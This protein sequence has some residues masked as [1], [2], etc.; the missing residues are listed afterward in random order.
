MSIKKEQAFVFSVLLSKNSYT[1]KPKNAG[2]LR[3][4]MVREYR[5]SVRNLANCLL[6][7]Y[8]VIPAYSNVTVTRDGTGRNRFRYD[9][10]RQQ[11][12]LLDIDNSDAGKPLPKTEQIPLKVA[13][14][15]LKLNGIVPCFAYR[16]YSDTPET[17]KFRIAVAFS[18][19]ITD[20][21]QRDLIQKAIGGALGTTKSGIPY[22]DRKCTDSNRIFYGTN[23]PELLYHDFDAVNS[24]NSA[25]FS[26][27]AAVTAGQGSQPTQAKMPQTPKIKAF[28]RSVCAD[29]G[30][31]EAI[32]KHDYEY[33]R[34]E[35]NCQHR[36]FK[37]TGEM[38]D[39][40]YKGVN[41]ADFL[42]VPE[43]TLFSC[44]IDGHTDKKPSA[45]IFRSD[46]GI[47]LYK[48]FSHAGRGTYNI[49]EFTE[50]VG[51]FKT[52]FSAM[53]FLKKCLNIELEISDWQQEQIS[54]LENIGS[55]IDLG[56]FAET[57]PC[58][59]KVTRFCRD[60]FR[61]MLTLAKTYCFTEEYTT[62][63]GEAVF[64]ATNS[65]ILQKSGRRLNRKQQG[66]VS[67]YLAILAYVGMIRKLPDNEV[68]KRLLQKARNIVK[69]AG[70][71]H[72]QFYSI[73][74]WVV[75]QT[76]LIETYGKSYI[77][78][79]YRQ[80][81]ISFETFYRT[82]GIE[83]AA[84]VYPQVARTKTAKTGTTYQQDKRH[85]I[86]SDLFADSIMEKGYARENAVIQEAK[87]KLGSYFS[88]TQ[89][90]RSLP[91]I[92]TA[93][94]WKRVR[95]TKKMKEQYD[96][97]SAGYPFVIIPETD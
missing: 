90:K 7:G 95:A 56:V 81:G 91:D 44:C 97:K 45:N 63:N 42:G 35:L 50:K 8:A 54:E 96:I 64:F 31:I 52:V 83:T 47:W 9:F 37:S 74:S 82:E 60:I 28:S 24:V 92:M 29:A 11:V 48:C 12:F 72:I 5:T 21:N 66:Q 10:V 19:P 89:V 30:I 80:D 69:G 67:K 57:C 36:I 77:E 22:V 51:G 79:G 23:K 33:I 32:Q 85:E 49:R 14:Q 58:A 94:R 4:E 86:V 43:K 16:T 41:F 73:P 34:Q 17:P 88:I 40:L 6:N 39:F 2:A 38:W 18:E 93:N 26:K 53:E 20:K 68:P 70:K 84:R 78:H 62:K 15:S 71:R 1:E 27:L 75:Q 87:S 76:E 55:C 59:Y 25:F 13:I 65:A 46:S 61:T 3:A